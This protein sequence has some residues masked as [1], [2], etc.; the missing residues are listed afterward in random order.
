MQYDGA[1]H[2]DHSENE[3]LSTDGG[4]RLGLTS[5]GGGGTAAGGGARFGLK[6]DSAGFVLFFSNKKKTMR[7]KKNC[8]KTAKTTNPKGFVEQLRLLASQARRRPEAAALA[9]LGSALPALVSR[10]LHNWRNGV[11]YC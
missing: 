8:E 5:S 9:S 11:S 2:C 3:L 10:E 1:L 7:R 4:A 6:S